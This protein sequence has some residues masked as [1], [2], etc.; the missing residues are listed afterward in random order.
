M[1]TRAVSG[2]EMYQHHSLC[3]EVK[4]KSQHLQINIPLLGHQ[5][6]QNTL[7]FFFLSQ[8]S[9]LRMPLSS[10]LLEVLIQIIE[11]SRGCPLKSSNPVCFGL[12]LRK[13]PIQFKR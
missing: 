5:E 13:V 1:W 12:C 10:G 7:E 9:A 2:Q 4:G 8:L 11:A 3:D 6:A